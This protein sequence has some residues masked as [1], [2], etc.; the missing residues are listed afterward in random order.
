MSPTCM[1]LQICCEAEPRWIF[2]PGYYSSETTFG[3]LLR[4]GYRI[5]VQTAHGY[6]LGSFT[7]CRTACSLSLLNPVF[8][9]LD[10]DSVRR[11]LL[12]PRD[13]EYGLASVI[14]LLHVCGGSLLRI[15]CWME[16][17]SN[18]DD[19]SSVY[20]ERGGM[21]DSSVMQHWRMSDRFPQLI[22]SSPSTDAA[23]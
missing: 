22:I 12:L 23:S 17:M 18:V 2:Q 19:P 7:C 15:A 3:C 13:V 1:P 10:S 4:P 16:L 5:A 21:Q 6:C 11:H 14:D 9:Q 20:P 8:G